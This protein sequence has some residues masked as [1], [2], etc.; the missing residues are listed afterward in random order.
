MDIDVL[1]E[2]KAFS[3]SQT[4]FEGLPEYFVELHEQTMKTVM[5]LVGTNR[6]TYTCMALG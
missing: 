5:I 3:L 4:D 6:P 2:R 1:D